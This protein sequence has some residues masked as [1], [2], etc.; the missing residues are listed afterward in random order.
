MILKLKKPFP[1]GALLTLFVVSV[2]LSALNKIHDTDAWLHLS[3]GRL[4]W[5]MKAVPN[6]ELFTYPIYGMPFSYN[7]WLF[8]LLCYALNT[9][10]GA[11]G[12]VLLKAS[13]LAVAFLILL[14]DSLRPYNNYAIAIIVMTAVLVI[15]HYRFVIRPD[16]FLMVFLS[17][18]IFSLNA[19]LYEN[20]KYI[21]A[22]PLVHL[23]WAN[24]HASVIVMFVPFLAFIGG[25]L[26]QH[27]LGKRGIGSQNSLSKSQLK[28]ITLVFIASFA[29]TLLTPFPFHQYFYG[30]QVVSS[31]WHTQEISELLPPSGGRKIFLYLVVAVVSASF[32]LNGRRMSFIHLL[33][34]LP[35][36][37]LPFVS[38]RFKFLIAITAG[39]VMVRNISA[40]LESK[41]WS[42]FHKNVLMAISAVCVVAYGSLMVARA[43]SHEQFGFGFDYFLMPKG[44]VEYMDRKGIYGRM[45]NTFHFGQYI[46]WTGYPKRTVFID[47]RGHLPEEL[48]EKPQQFRSSP[49]VLDE[50]YKTYGF[51]SILVRYLKPRQSYGLSSDLDLSFSHPQWALVYW[52]DISLLYLKRGGRY[53]RVIKNSEYR[54][55]KPNM[56]FNH[57]ITQ[58]GDKEYQ[59]NLIKELKRTIAETGSLR[60]RVFLGL[61]YSSGGFYEEAIDTL[62]NVR[63][64]HRDEL[65][66]IAYAFTGDSYRNLGDL[67]KGLYFYRKALSSGENA[68]LLYKIGILRLAKEE[69]KEALKHLEKALTLNSEMAHA[70]PMLIYTYQTLG[71]NEKAE[72]AQKKYYDLQSKSE[73]KK[74]FIRGLKAFFERNYDVAVKEY[75]KALEVDPFVPNIYVNLGSAY[76]KMG[77][78]DEA[79]ESFNIALRLNPDHATAH[80]GLAQ[81][82]KEHGNFEMAKNHFEEYIRIE[83]SGN[84]SRKANRQIK[85]LSRR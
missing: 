76:T 73:G 65:K 34:V 35:F 7:S 31:A 8:G 78:I 57:F 6:V 10:F 11:Y 20:K 58:T 83:P 30:P 55:M 47:A 69:P 21:Y 16:M 60:A 77:Q 5:E 81:L 50:M 13:V 67:D 72:E 61:L 9:H 70:Y 46:I 63:S 18:S 12:L 56:S 19:F 28:I 4:I 26:I 24:M 49:S 85:E 33:L 44:A 62:A 38:V 15:S 74:H 41:G 79:Y 1:E 43:V 59:E 53:D 14:K 36:L 27:Y 71:M 52:D 37:Y 84:L 64:G 32:V 17:F 42:A 2:F 22:L 3:L 80:Y 54:F 39:P 68:S 23:F 40:F 25:S 51:E 29:A 66:Y 75:K 82:Y 48:L 45:L